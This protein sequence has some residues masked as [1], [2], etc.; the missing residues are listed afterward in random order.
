MTDSTPRPLSRHPRLETGTLV[1]HD[2]R[3]YRIKDILNWSE[4]TAS[5]VETRK[6]TV[7]P[8]AEIHL[9]APA[10]AG[11]RRLALDGLTEKQERTAR[12]RLDAIEP[13]LDHHSIED[14]ASR[15]A[16]MGCSARTL[17]RWIRLYTATGDHTSLVPRKRGWTEG[18]TRIRATAEDVVTEV[19]D[20]YYLT[21]LR[22]GPKKVIEEVQRVCVK[23]NITPPSPSTIRRRLARVPEHTRL[24]R[25]GEPNRARTR[26]EPAAGSFPS[27]KHPLQAVQIDHTEAD[28]VLVDDIS[29][30]PIGRPWLTVA[31]DVYSRVI[32]GYYLSLDSPSILSVGMCVIHS[33][34][35]KEKWLISRDLADA[36]WP[37]WGFP[38][39]IHV[40]NGPDFRSSD[41]Q[42]ACVKHGVSITYRPLDRTNYGGHVE[43]LIGNIMANLRGVPGFT[44]SSV[45]ERGEQDPES[46]AAMTMR[47][48]DRWLLIWIC[49]QYHHETHRT[50]LTSPIDRWEQGIFGNPTAPGTGIQFR[51]RSPDDLIRDFLPSVERTVQKTGVTVDGL[52]YYGE[53]L[54][55]WI[56]KDDPTSRRKMKLRFRR[57][58]RDISQLWFYDPKADHYYKIPLADQSIPPMSLWEYEHARK[59]LKS[60]AK[61]RANSSQIIRA[62][63]ERR[64]VEEDAQSATREAKRARRNRQRRADHAAALD[65]APT[66]PTAPA[67]PD[68]E[69]GSDLSY[70]P[71]G[72][73]ETID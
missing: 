13:L 64:K 47:E 53:P 58:P 40:D 61:L 54:R 52:R 9:V 49:K 14:V 70:E 35:P 68:H 59:Q 32:T 60:Q 37:V 28:V 38:D 42:A 3:K 1:E 18:N 17:Y 8:T 56:G 4:V 2:G 44:G 72:R 34:L 7:L 46:H 55:P 71:V 19:I 50:T 65:P 22:P 27:A 29:R 21:Q 25:R 26:Y 62:I 51:H 36:E 23:R 6:T 63:D 43:R 5:D 48:L 11:A 67:E 16:E 45:A 69:A 24:E 39:M 10:N 41:I 15:A 20:T 31:I 33:I 66:L 12:E 57:D 73:L 30:R